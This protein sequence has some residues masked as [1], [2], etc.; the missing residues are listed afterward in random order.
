MINFQSPKL[1][2]SSPGQKLL[3]IIGPDKRDTKLLNQI[4][5]PEI[6]R[7]LKKRVIWRIH[8]ETVSDSMADIV[9]RFNRQTKVRPR[10]KREVFIPCKTN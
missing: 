8:T 2:S 7:L 3:S 5:M 1:I 9:Y 6:I 4:I 10:I